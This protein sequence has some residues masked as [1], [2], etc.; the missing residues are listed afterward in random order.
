MSE[1]RISEVE[2]RT[3]VSHRHKERMAG[4]FLK[5]PIS[6]RDISEASCLGGRALAVFLAIHHQTALTGTP[7]VTLP[8]GLLADMGMDKDAKARALQALEAAGLIQVLQQRGKSA[9]V[10]VASRRRGLL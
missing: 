1:V 7:T 8:K 3:A 2:V 4:R 9:R 6:M 5:G 10:S